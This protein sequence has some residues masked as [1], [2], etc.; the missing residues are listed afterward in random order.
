MRLG[1][2]A[3]ELCGRVT[4]VG[5]YLA[6]LL[7][8]WSEDDQTRHHEFVLYA[9]EAIALSLDSGRF[10]LRIVPGRPG[11]MWE[12]VRLPRAATSDHLDAWFAP[13]YTAPLQLNIPTVVAIHDLSFV[14]H[15]EWFRLREGAR[16]RWLT[17]QAAAAALAVITISQFSKRELIERLHVP[18][19]K[20][21]VIPP[22]VSKN[23][24]PP[25]PQSLIPGHYPV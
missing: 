3:R 14:A 10:A 6:G 1:I 25:H 12:Q 8:E 9:P 21:H 22:G 11:T 19:T 20:I 17:G 15:P 23:A 13:G 2:D 18:E 4:G 7:T 5:R 16:R 24:R